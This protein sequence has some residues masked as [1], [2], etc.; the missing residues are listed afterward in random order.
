MADYRSYRD[1][2]SKRFMESIGF[3]TRHDAVYPDIAFK[4]P[5]PPPSDRQH[6]HARLVVGVGVMTYQGWRNQAASGA[7]IYQAYL[8]KITTFVLWLLDDDRSVRILM[9]DAADLRA[10]DDLLANVSAARPDLASN[11]LVFDPVSSLH[12]LMRRIAETDVV[13]ATR[14]HNVVCALK[15][16][17]PTVSIGYA[18]KND[19]LMA[20]M[21]LGRFCQHVERLNLDLLIEQFN[22]LIADRQRYERG[23]EEADRACRARL[24]HQDALLAARVL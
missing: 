23:I 18:E 15:L 24:D 3:D 11:R 13:V 9:G 19:V 21:G 5:G 1:A 2:I 17:K 10:V 4:L 12:D 6:S 20:E 16:G 7:A 8:E 14:Y 22:R